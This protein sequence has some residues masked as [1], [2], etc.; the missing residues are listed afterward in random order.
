M[1]K[2]IFIFLVLVSVGLVNAA[3]INNSKPQITLIFNETVKL[4]DYSLSSNFFGTNYVYP[5]VY[6]TTDNK[7]FIFTSQNY[8]N[9][10]NYTFRI[11]ATDLVNNTLEERYREYPFELSVGMNIY[12]SLIY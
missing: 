4:I 9:D 12:L 1:K 10:G 6:T 8:L 5:L 2:I 3:S 11:L 7:T